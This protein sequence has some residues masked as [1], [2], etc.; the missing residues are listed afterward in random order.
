MAEVKGGVWK[1]TGNNTL[2]Y[3]ISEISATGKV[4]NTTVAKIAGLATLTQNAAGSISV[5]NPTD[6]STTVLA[7]NTDYG[8]D[9]APVTAT[10]AGGASATVTSY[11]GTINLSNQIIGTSKLTLTNGQYKLDSDEAD[12]VDD[13]VFKTSKLKISLPDESKVKIKENTEKLGTYNK[14]KGTLTITGDLTGGYAIAKDGLTATYQ[15]FKSGQTVATISGLRTGLTDEDWKKTVALTAKASE[16]SDSSDGYNGL[17]TLSKLQTVIG[18]T[19]TYTNAGSV[20]GNTA[21]KVTTNATLANNGTNYYLGLSAANAGDHGYAQGELDEYEDEAKWT[22]NKTTATYKIDLPVGYQLAN[23]A[24]ETVNNETSDADEAIGQKATQIKVTAAISKPIVTVSN[25]L[26]GLKVSEGGKSVGVYSKVDLNSD[27]DDSNDFLTGLTAD[28]TLP[29]DSNSKGEVEVKIGRNALPTTKAT[30]QAAAG[31]LFSLTGGVTFGGEDYGTVVSSEPAKGTDYLDIWV[32]SGTTATLKR[33]DTAWYKLEGNKITST[34]QTGGVVLATIKNL[35][36]DWLK[37]ENNLTRVVNGNANTPI[38]EI[39]GIELSADYKNNYEYSATSKKWVVNKGQDNKPFGIGTITLSNQV[40]TTKSVTIGASDNFKLFVRQEDG[41]DGGTGLS[42]VSTPSFYDG[43]WNLSGTTATYKGGISAGYIVSNDGKT[44]TY[45][46]DG[47]NQELAKITGLKKGVVLKV[48]SDGKRTIGYST[49]GGFSYGIQTTFDDSDDTNDALTY[50]S[51]DSETDKFNK[52]KKL[53][54]T[55]SRNVLDTTNVAITSNFF[56]LAIDKDASDEDHFVADSSDAD[57]KIDWHGT[58]GTNA[59]LRSTKEAYYTVNDT[60][61]KWGQDI[62]YTPPA[63]GGTTLA[64]VK[65]LN[66]GITKDDIS[67]DTVRGAITIENEN[68]VTTKSVTLTGGG[69]SSGVADS[70]KVAEKFYLALGESSGLSA[71]VLTDGKWTQATTKGNPITFKAEVEGGYQVSSDSMAINYTADSTTPKVLASITGLKGKLERVGGSDGDSFQFAGVSFSKETGVITL[72]MQALND[73]NVKLTNSNY[74]LSIASDVPTEAG[75]ESGQSWVISGTTATYKEVGSKAYYQLTDNNTLKYNP[76][77]AASLKNNYVTITGLKSGLTVS[78]SGQSIG[79]YNASGSFVT[80]IMMD[81]NDSAGSI[82]GGKLTIVD[83]AALT[84]GNIKISDKASLT[85]GSFSI[86]LGASLAQELSAQLKDGSTPTWSITNKGVATYKGNV[87]AY[88]TNDDNNLGITYH[89][90][91]DNATIATITNLATTLGN[92]FKT[93]GKVG[94]ASGLVVDD[95]TREIAINSNML[96]TSTLGAVLTTNI[97]ISGA[98]AYK[99]KLG[100]DVRTYADVSSQDDAVWVI[101]NA[102][103]ATST[104]A[105]RSIWTQA[106]YSLSGDSTT[107]TYKPTGVS[108]ELAKIEGLAKGLGTIKGGEINGLSVAGTSSTGLGLDTGVVT[109]LNDDVIISK[110]DVTLTDLDSSDGINYSLSIAED[111]ASIKPQ[112][113]QVYKIDDQPSNDHAVINMYHADSEGYKVVDGQLSTIISG[114]S[115]TLTTST[116]KYNEKTNVTES[117]NIIAKISGLK[118]TITPVTVSTSAGASARTDG[119]DGI[120]F[121]RETGIFKVSNKVLD[122]TNVTATNI[123]TILSDFSLAIDEDVPAPLNEGPGWKIHTEQSGSRVNTVAGAF[124]LY[125]NCSAP[126]YSLTSATQI[127]YQTFTGGGDNQLGASISGLASNLAINSYQI[128]GISISSD[129]TITLSKDVLA[130]KDVTLTNLNSGNYKL[131]I[132]SDSAITD[133]YVAP[134]SVSAVWNYNNGTATYKESMKEGY[135]L[136]SDGL[137]VE[138]TPTTIVTSTLTNLS[139]ENVKLINGGASISGISYADGVFTITDGNILAHKKVTLTAKDSK[140]KAV[141]GYKLALGEG[142]GASL[143]PFTWNKT[144]TDT[145]ATLT[146]VTKSGYTVSTDGKAIN[147]SSDP[148]T[149]TLMTITGLKKANVSASAV[150][151]DDDYAATIKGIVIG[152][153]SAGGESALAHGE[154]IASSFVENASGGYVKIS[155]D[156]LTN[157]NVTLGKNDNYKLVLDA[158]G[159]DSVATA[160]EDSQAW[161]VVNKTTATYKNIKTPY[162]ALTNDKTIT[163]K[164]ASIGSAIVNIS[165]LR[166]G[167]TPNAAGSIAGIEID[168]DYANNTTVTLSA[169]ALPTVAGTV[170]ISSGYALDLDSEVAQVD[171]STSIA[172]GVVSIT[173]EGT[174]RESVNAWV[175]EGS[176]YVYRLYNP[177]YYTLGKTNDT[178]EVN[179]KITSTA[180]KTLVNYFSITGLSAGMTLTDSNIEFTNDSDYSKGGIITISEDMLDDKT[181]KLTSNYNFKLTVESGGVS[182]AELSFADNPWNVKGTN[183]TLKG[184]YGKGYALSEDGKTLTYYSKDD[185]TTVN[186]ATLTGIKSG[187]ALTETVLGGLS[188][189]EATDAG[190]FMNITLDKTQLGTAKV[191]LK[192]DHLKLAVSDAQGKIA[193]QTDDPTWIKAANATTATYTQTTYAG[194]SPSA[195]GKALNYLSKTTPVHLATITGLKK[196]LTVDDMFGGDSAAV[197][198]LTED[199][200]ITLNE[201]TKTIK[202]AGLSALTTAN[203]TLGKNDVYT[204]VFNDIERDYIDPNITYD[205]K[206]TA[207]IKDGH[208]AGYKLT[209]DKTITYAKETSSLLASISNLP[210]NTTEGLTL[211][212]GDDSLKVTIDT[213]ALSKTA[214]AAKL[215]N[216]SADITYELILASD[217]DYT[218]PT[219]TAAD[220]KWTNYDAAKGN[221]TLKSVM[222]EGY[223]LGTATSLTSGASK[224]AMTQTVSYTAEKTPN[225]LT[226]LSGLPKN[227]FDLRSGELYLKGT[228]EKAFTFGTGAD[229]VQVGASDSLTGYVQNKGVETTFKLSGGTGDYIFSNSDASG[230]GVGSTIETNGTVQLNFIGSG[231]ATYGKPTQANWKKTND[232][233]EYKYTPDNPGAFVTINGLATTASVTGNVV[234]SENDHQVTVS[235]GALTNSKVTFTYPPSTS[236]K[237]EFVLGD[238]VYTTGKHENEWKNQV[239]WVTSGGTATYKLYNKANYT[240]STVKGGGNQINYVAPT[241]GSAFA[242]IS[243]LNKTTASITSADISGDGVISLNPEDLNASKVTLNITNVKKV[244]DSIVAASIE[245]GNETAANFTLTLANDVEK[246]TVSNEY[247][248]TT[249]TTA[250]LTGSISKGYRLAT[251]KKSVLY[252]SKDADG[253]TIATITGLKKDAEIDPSDV[254]V[255]SDDSFITNVSLGSDKLTTTKVAIKGEGYKLVLKDDVLDQENEWKNKVDWFASNGTFT[256][257]TYN[258]AHYTANALGTEIAYTALKDVQQH[259]VI[260]GLN[261]TV[262]NDNV[263]EYATIASGVITL[264]DEALNKANVTFTDKD[265]GG[266]TLALSANS[267]VKS[268]VDSDSVAAVTSGTAAKNATITGYQSEG[269]RLNNDAQTFTYF[270]ATNAAKKQNIA[271]ITGLAN[272]VTNDSVAVLYSAE[273]NAVSLSAD[274][275]YD[276]KKVG[277]SGTAAFDFGSGVT[278]YTITGSKAADRVTVQGGR[279]IVATNDGN[280]YIVVGGAENS[281]NSGAGNNRILISSEKNSIVAGKGNDYINISSGTANSINSGAGIDHFIIATNSNSIL[282]G[283]GNDTIEVTGASNTINAG[284][285]NDY[286]DLGLN[287]T[288]TSTLFYA[289]GDGADVIAHFK[290]GDTFKVTSYTKAQ[291]KISFLA[292]SGSDARVKV[293]S[294]TITFKGAANVAFKVY[295]SVGA[296]V[297]THTVA[298]GAGNN[299]ILAD[300]NYSMTPQLSSIV[301][302]STTYMTEDLVATDATS[303]TKQST[304]IAYGGKK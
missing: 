288:G 83:E 166:S 175:E 236:D 203:M 108:K 39:K 152:S 44:I 56:K 186:L 90:A 301:K 54:I 85:S 249:K 199:K 143:E 114:A 7:E 163:Y 204:F 162:Y 31:G 300:D 92:S 167:L 20:L 244:S 267:T 49:T 299:N 268:T 251:N 226:T 101:A 287:N 245:T 189:F 218:V 246:S 211:G 24:G 262:T 95:D 119:F 269:Y 134:P 29:A 50:Y 263:S 37:D 250:K 121:D 206:G 258:R 66:S 174:T 18:G 32:V 235:A 161:S 303:L 207:N 62:N 126:G 160:A 298:E 243:G 125:D 297:G 171:S 233:K 286:I 124:E 302:G 154:S 178:V 284:K 79:Y 93:D 168:S 165:G 14:S 48:D 106:H 265:V 247:W 264:S 57:N 78:Q 290:S 238:D 123:A 304:A 27:N 146:Q 190:S 82:E 148:T 216:K 11:T 140:N 88:Y 153:F 122:N 113:S 151:Y 61:N 102:K 276:T 110:E 200:L 213:R 145:K 279:N 205:G 191:A 215:T 77:A 69:Y 10:V 147:Y 12:L 64:I 55:L 214:T 156:V 224:G 107:L 76:A 289:N 159:T 74:S 285:G 15:A 21:I 137:S 179:N 187:A 261:K 118:K 253:Q 52:L 131:A 181:V 16:D 99:F 63:T 222:T 35:N 89:A 209:N 278:S 275:L 198:A 6:G 47:T 100:S 120:E 231:K 112:K 157:T 67:F 1:L 149:A 229:S 105:T 75:G 277:I 104:T 197:A 266:Y 25:L 13:T 177:G 201:T 155:K 38:T 259:A 256:Y 94:S 255:S 36:G 2:S 139:K 34:A 169:E 72:G 193:S 150:S 270:N 109:F 127:T 68:A 232:N 132:V 5:V 217:G 41:S 111:I 196:E 172:A 230:A 60:V 184:T 170:T 128:A 282:A 81:I 144:E 208:K 40:L 43:K 295:D 46:A 280:D 65:G 4:T 223:T 257:K 23:A 96:G 71:P 30:V 116:L 8:I 97:A 164:A 86:G 103:N 87:Q 219:A 210:K 237:Y 73:A 188:T 3:V 183:A 241:K 142:V 292:D 135:E 58:L 115:A 239:D 221:A 9:I 195:N 273:N 59:T 70:L 84:T 91:K 176:N 227:I 185:G 228:D 53:D 117:N 133:K 293:N 283:D 272:T 242:A 33:V 240:L 234:A 294:T 98:S 180:A 192:G 182:A 51:D 45:T 136:S 173:A 274:N 28:F 252:Y 42:A 202:V 17:I 260:G 130:S 271:V 254:A 281:V 212:T 129:K 141:D 220:P 291:N 26:S 158:D 194:F 248:D 138:Y 19:S 80:A 22:I 296:E 225:I